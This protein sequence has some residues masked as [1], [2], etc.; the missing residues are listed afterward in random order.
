MRCLTLADELRTGGADILF[1]SRQLDGNLGEMV[2]CR[3][4]RLRMLPQP[5]GPIFGRGGAD[6]A[7]WLGVDWKVDA[8]QTLEVLHAEQMVSWLVV[9]SYS[10]DVRWELMIRPAV[11]RVMVIDDLADRH[12]DADLL[13]DQNLYRDLATRYE[14]LLSPGCRTLLGPRYA[15]LRPEFPE[16]RKS[17]RKRDGSVA[18]I[19][20]FFGGSDRTNETLKALKGIQL[21][22]RPDIAVDVV[23]GINHQHRRDVETFASSLAQTICHYNVNNMAELIARADLFLGAA[24]TTTWE[25]CCLG[26]P[27]LVITVAQNQVQATR[28]LAGAGLLSFVGESRLVSHTD[29][30]DAV[31]AAIGNPLLLKTFSDASFE[32]VDGLGATRCAAAILNGNL[33]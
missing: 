9:D 20:V 22:S 13:L 29:V 14:G 17:L 4:H 24:G 1:I 23:L 15:L 19:L 26:L 5:P 25:R 21:L 27:S 31:C 11:E 33:G 28:D 3:R 30:T 7:C 10:L 32:L 2:T 6:H 18:R 12:H 16:S 8:A